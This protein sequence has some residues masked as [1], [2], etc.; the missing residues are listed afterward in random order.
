MCSF[1]ECIF[2]RVGSLP[3]L[4]FT[5]LFFSLLYYFFLHHVNELLCLRLILSGDSEV[6]TSKVRLRGR[7]C[8]NAVNSPWS[9]VH[10][11]LAGLPVSLNYPTNPSGLS[12]LFYYLLLTTYCLPLTPYY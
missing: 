2:S 1:D 8:D 7:Q 4:Q 3:L 11:L 12:L 10:G 6:A 5:S 9:I